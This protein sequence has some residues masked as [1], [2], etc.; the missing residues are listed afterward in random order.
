MLYRTRGSS[1]T[2]LQV[3]NWYLR[4]EVYD[5]SDGSLAG[6][7]PRVNGLSYDDVNEAWIVTD[8]DHLT[9]WTFPCS[10]YDIYFYVA[11]LQ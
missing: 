6:A 8:I 5:K 4:V 2:C 1:T 9:P 7:L 3:T 11:D 10:Q